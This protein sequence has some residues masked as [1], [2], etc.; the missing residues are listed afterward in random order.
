MPVNHKPETS[1]LLK[2]FASA[3][4]AA[5]LLLP[6]L[7]AGSG[8]AATGP[9]I[10]K[11]SVIVWL[12]RRGCY[13][14]PGVF[15]DK[16]MC[17]LPNM[18]FRVNGPIES[19]TNFIVEYSLGKGP[20]L[21]FEVNGEPEPEGHWYSF[22]RVGSNADDEKA[23]QYTGP[24]TVT[25]RASNELQG[26][27]QLLYKGT[28]QVKKYL[29]LDPKQFPDFKDK[30]DYYVDQDWR[31]PFGYLTSI[32]TTSGYTSDNSN[33]T[34]P[35]IA[36]M[37]FRG[38]SSALEDS[39]AHLYYQGKHISKATP[40]TKGWT[41]S[42]TSKF[43]WTETTFNFMGASDSIPV[44]YWISGDEEENYP[45]AF[46][47]FK[48]PGEYEIKVLHKGALSRSMKFTVGPDGKVVDNGFSTQLAA[49]GMW[50][51]PVKTAAQT[52]GPWD[53]K[54]WQTNAFY[55]N[56]VQGFQAP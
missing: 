8:H 14:K 9:T 50:M 49:M 20:Y 47:L 1:R 56:P 5:A 2:K 12:N 27:N 43:N 33:H 39:E 16:H 7:M 53:A 6:G 4:L 23:T 26:M 13:S 34:P 54:L 18:D 22:D 37:W 48:N 51:M 15:D 40:G 24:V 17:W 29:P 55:A 21:T 3:A 31:M 19:G 44:F 32:W 35:L 30:Y 42:E 46:Q 10:D 28:L 36:K 41:T 11:S 25:I 38:D 45:T 52:D